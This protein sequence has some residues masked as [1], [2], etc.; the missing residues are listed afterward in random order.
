MVCSHR[1][2]TKWTAIAERKTPA[3]NVQQSSSGHNPS[4]KGAA[5]DV[6]SGPRSSLLHALGSA[7]PE[8][9]SSGQRPL[10]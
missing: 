9:T 2:G 1:S 3:G 5:D 10:P 6:Y 7:M 8:C 4:A